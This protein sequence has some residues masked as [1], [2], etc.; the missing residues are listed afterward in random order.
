MPKGAKPIVPALALLAA[1]IGAAFP[2]LAAGAGPPPIGA[3]RLHAFVNVAATALMMLYLALLVV[4]V[5]TGVRRRPLDAA[6]AAGLALLAFAVR[7]ASSDRVPIGVANGDL[8]HVADLQQWA[9]AGLGSQLDVTYPPAWRGL[10]YVAFQAFGPSLDLA[11]AATTVTGALVA[12]PVYLLGQRLSGRR[13]GG[14]LAGLAFVAS[15]VAILFANGLGLEVPASALLALV[16]VHALDAAKGR[17]PIDA[18]LLVLSMA[19]FVQTRLE[20]LGAA[21]VVLAMLAV[22]TFRNGGWPAV[23]RLLPWVLVAALATAPFLWTV[24]GQTLAVADNAAKAS[25]MLIPAA[26]FLAATLLIAW[27]SGRAAGSSWPRGLAEDAVRRVVGW[28]LA[29][30][31]VAVAWVTWPNSPWVPQAVRPDALPFYEL[32]VTW[33]FGQQ[34]DERLFPKWLLGLGVF[35]LPFLLAWLASVVPSR[36]LPA[37]RHAPMA[38]FLALLPWFGHYLTREVGTG[39]APLEGLRHHVLFAGVVSVS[40]GLGAFR[41][42]GGL[43]GRIRVPA[44]AWGA[45][46]LVLLSP[47]GT[48]RS[49]YADTDFDSQREFRFVRDAVTRLPDRALILVPGDVVDFGPD[50][51]IPPR[52]IH[53]VFRTR[54]LWVGTAWPAGRQVE[55]ESV[56][57]AARQGVPSNVPLYFYQGLECYRAV[58]PDTFLPS[59]RV[60]SDVLGGRAVASASFPNR[61]YSAQSAE[62]IGIRVPGVDLALFPMDAGDLHEIGRRLAAAPSGGM[63][64]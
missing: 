19:L 25:G 1:G 21:P 46:G 20:G 29:G 41:V 24:L 35:P 59:C 54:D 12:V 45:A 38:V 57:D 14:V 37:A 10:L 47:L 40:V 15:P 6:I 32:H 23:R 60:A 8:T 39:I 56:Q 48:H 17:R 13:A 5:A 22:V 26:A 11:F 2:A 64:P 58:H 33:P 55:V 16:F 9:R 61:P 7:W 36:S 63:T 34:P 31:C 43:A 50:A 49:C 44:V 28:T 53:R 18:A 27:D 4:R 3:S 51:K 42:A 30:I 62:R 52:E